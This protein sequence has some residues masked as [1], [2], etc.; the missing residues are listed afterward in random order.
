MKKIFFSLF[1]LLFLFSCAPVSE[2]KK[3][4]PEVTL[5]D[6]ELPKTVAVLP[7][8]NKTEEKGIANQVRKSFYNHFSSKPYRDIEL[9]IV[10]EKIIQL[11]RQTGKSILEIPPQEV[12][13]ALG[14]DGLIYG[15]VTD[16]KKIYAVAY[17]QLGIE[18]EV[19]MINTRTGKEV[20]RIKDSVRYHE[21]GVPLS[22]LSAVMTAISTAMNIRDIQQVRMI[23]ELCYKFN[24]KIPSPTGIV[25]ERPVIKE[26]LTNVKESPFGKGKVIQVG[27]EGDRGMVA[28]FDIGNFKK[29]IPMKET[30]PGIYI[31]EY[32]VLPGDNV[33]EA[34]VIVSLRKPAGYET[35]WI[36]VSGFVTID[37]TPPPQVKGL[38]AKG[39]YD[40]IELSWEPLRDVTDLKGY[41]ILR[42]QQPLTGFEE[43]G[44]VEFNHFEDRAVEHGKTYYYRV[45]AFDTAG[46]ESEIQD[47]VKSS[48]TTKEPRS[49]SGTAEKDTVLSG[50]YI[51][52]Q[53]FIIP[54][55]LTL[56]IEPETRLMFAENASLVVYGKIN[57]NAKDAPV[58]F[59]SLNDKKWKG[60]MIE[61]GYANMNGFIIKNAITGISSSSSEGLIENGIITQ[62]DRGI[63]VASVPA[64]VF[65]NLTISD[66]RMG[67][68]LLKTSSNIQTSNIF[69]NETGIKINGF[70][71][72]IMDN[73]IYD[74]T[75][76]VHSETP[77]KLD[78]NYFGSI[79]IDEMKIKN[80]QISKV[81]DKRLPDG[82]VV[83]AISNP[84]SNLSQEE[85][86]KKATEYLI[87][88]GNYFRQRNYGKAVKLFEETLKAQPSPEVYYYLALSYQEM[89]EDDNALKY[90]KEGIEKFPKDPTLQKSLGL[91][92]YQMGKEEEAKKL[93]E[94]VLRLNPEDRQV[95]FLIERMGK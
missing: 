25:E 8:E 21:G 10:D 35:Q 59:L 11:E 52:R 30:Q 61:N 74:N 4:T 83:D 67:I 45:I 16:Y 23:N 87:E 94:E 15:K 43:I 53:D 48:L 76:N 1:F 80:V 65:K 82:R 88:A 24:E 75:V 68:E 40:R 49:L 50:T 13:R 86:Q 44:K 34:P 39:F 77:V 72:E 70:S 17:S 56:T 5:A 79:N 81:Y 36:D 29:G 14:C 42:S 28:T 95:K 20:F 64:P 51:I 62:C 69:Q 93:F 55:G 73:N 2:I 31:G 33:K 91:M 26:V 57:V 89:K 12:C 37:T 41:K 84:Y 78:K 22:P 63:L 92:Y 46:N 38:K 60:I 66:N 19:W 7:F 3:E 90:L 9:S 6:E 47:A 18:A 27:L 71:G 54:K 58:E 32:V 85:R